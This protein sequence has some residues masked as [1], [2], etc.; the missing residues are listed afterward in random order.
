MD[1]AKMKLETFRVFG[2]ITEVLVSN[3][4]RM[5]EQINIGVEKIASMA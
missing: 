3:N 4:Q 5:N 1:C 2:I